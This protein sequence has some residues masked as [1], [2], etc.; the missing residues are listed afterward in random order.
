MIAWLRG[1]C[2]TVAEDHV[3]VDV[4]G[5]G[6]LV[7]ISGRDA[8][9]LNAGEEAEL[10]IFTVVREDSFSLYGF[11]TLAAREM[12]RTIL[13]ISGVGPKGALALLAA[14]SPAE[15]ARAIHDDQPKPLTV[16]K[17]IGKRTAELIVVR[18][19]ER[20]PP[21]LL[22]GAMESSPASHSP[23]TKP[24]RDAKSALVNL[25]FR[26]A[27][28]E[29]AVMDAAQS[30]DDFEQLLRSSLTALRRPQA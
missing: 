2:Q 21:E 1:R 8:A 9:E 12:F 24:M 13:S 20:L 18:L 23:W 19:R 10:Q 16:A 15:I 7:Q 14:L 5:V 30:S 28:A 25:G 6:Y 4:Q 26:A 22:S 17:G 27:L 29:R 3:I 11:R